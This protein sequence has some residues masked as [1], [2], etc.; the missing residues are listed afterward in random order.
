MSQQLNYKENLDK[1]VWCDK[2]D[3]RKEKQNK[4]SSKQVTFVLKQTRGIQI[5]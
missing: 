4:K 3:S 1:M 5:L 2:M